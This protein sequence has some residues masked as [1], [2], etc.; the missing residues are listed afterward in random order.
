MADQFSSVVNKDSVDAMTAAKP[1]WTSPVP[2]AGTEEAQRARNKTAAAHG[3][4][5]LVMRAKGGPVKAGEGYVVGEKG[6]EKFVPSVNGKIIPTEKNMAEK[7]EEHKAKHAH[8]GFTETHMKHH[9][10]GSITVKH[11]HSEGPHKDVEHAVADLDGAHDSMQEHLG[12]PN[13]GEAEAD[14]G[15]E[16]A[17]AGAGAGAAPAAA[18]AAGM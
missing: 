15:P 18:P 11:M 6:P 12:M 1:S 14:A 2:L 13:P 7:K 4:K 5:P 17:A 3:T 9:H 10:D 16:A 8:H